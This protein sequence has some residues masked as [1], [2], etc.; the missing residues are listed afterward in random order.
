MVRPAIPGSTG[1]DQ[2]K[3]LR[4]S[5]SGRMVDMKGVIPAVGKRELDELYDKATEVLKHYEN[6]QTA[7]KRQGRAS[8]LSGTDVGEEKAGEAKQ[9]GS[10]GEDSEEDTDAEG[11]VNERKKEEEMPEQTKKE[12]ED[13][14]E[15]DQDESDEDDEDGNAEEGDE[16]TDD[17]DESDEDD[18]DGNAEEGD[19]KTD[20]SN[21]IITLYCRW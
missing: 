1:D 2:E 11:V 19:E 18:E 10:D 3:S 6:L 12:G 15:D 5:I 17:K 13:D 14:E 20:V 4:W 21:K 7:H 8:H 16:K 9:D